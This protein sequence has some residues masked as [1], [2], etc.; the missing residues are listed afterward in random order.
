MGFINVLDLKV[1]KGG[2]EV[3]LHMGKLKV[4]LSFDNED[5]A[6]EFLLASTKSRSIMTAALLHDCKFK[7]ARDCRGPG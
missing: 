7:G 2:W 6:T 4:I 5:D 1:D 3:R